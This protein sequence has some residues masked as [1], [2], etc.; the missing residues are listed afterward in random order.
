MPKMRPSRHS[1]L[2]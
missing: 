1:T 2:S